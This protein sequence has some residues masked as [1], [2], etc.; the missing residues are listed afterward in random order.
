MKYAVAVF[1][2]HVSA[3]CAHAQTLGQPDAH[4]HGAIYLKSQDIKWEKIMPEL[5]ERSP[6]SLS[7]TLNPLPRPRS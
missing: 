3:G 5:G 1:L 4:S 7:C 6:R 2:L